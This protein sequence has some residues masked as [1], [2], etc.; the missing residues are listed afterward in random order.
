[1]PTTVEID[2][3]QVEVYTAEEL[4]AQKKEASEAA[5]KTAAEKAAEETRKALEA[6]PNGIAARARR[7]AETKLKQAEKEK[8]DLQAQLTEAGKSAEQI[9]ELNEKLGQ[10]VQA[11]ADAKKSV[12]TVQAQ[13]Q[14]DLALIGEGAQAGKLAELKAVLGVRNIDVNDAA[15][16]TAA[17]PGLKTEMPGLFGEVK[18]QGYNPSPGSTNPPNTTGQPTAEE[19]EAM[20]PAQFHAY[21]NKK[22]T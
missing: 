5:A 17:L 14:R 22:G 21:M 12:E 2:G 11:E 18:T 4:E 16:V 13:H 7:D 9:K 15:A 10:A 1:M 19:L 20:S 6:D 8:T 3:K